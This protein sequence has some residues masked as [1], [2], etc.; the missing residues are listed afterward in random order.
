L[1]SRV[2]HFSQPKFIPDESFPCSSISGGYV[3]GNASIYTAND[4]LREAGGGVV[5]VV[6]Q[7]RLGLFGFLPGQKVK[8]DGLL[9]AGLCEL[10]F[11]WQSK[12][13]GLTRYFS[14]RNS[15]PTICSAMGAATC[16]H[17]IISL[18]CVNYILIAFAFY[19]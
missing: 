5:V 13:M 3:S 9:N 19:A 6:I 7:Y 15:G 12:M 4:L 18:Y 2:R 17:R 8:D 16:E 10:G 14:L 1:D 11:L